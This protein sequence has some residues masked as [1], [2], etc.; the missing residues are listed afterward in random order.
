MLSAWDLLLVVVGAAALWYGAEQFVAGAVTLARRVGLSDLVVGVVVV[1]IGTSLPE[2]AASVDAALAARADLAVGNAVGSN[3][4]NLGVVLGATALVTPV[5]ARRPLRRRDAPVMLAATVAVALAL[6]DLRLGRW[7]GLLLLAG[8]VGYLVALLSGDRGRTRRARTDTAPERDGLGRTRAVFLTAGGL[9]L[10][11]LGAD[12]LV[13]GAVGLALA[14]GVSEWVVGETVVALGTSS[15]ELAAAVAAARAGYPELAVGNVVG[16][17]VF[18]ALAVVGLVAVLAPSS[19][20]PAA[21]ATVWWLVGLTALV[22]VLLFTGRKLTR[23]EGGVAAAANLVRW[24]L[25]LL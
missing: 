12:V 4:V 22:T 1:G 19:V 16:S 3:L 15:P 24:G 7:E 18:N 21:T 6:W 17:C 2:V 20:T 8:L 23:A 10:V 13:R 14:A 11:V 5:R 9:V 25:D